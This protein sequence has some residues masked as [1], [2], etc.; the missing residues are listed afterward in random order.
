MVFFVDWFSFS[1]QSHNTAPVSLPEGVREE[2]CQGTNIYSYR[3]I[4]YYCGWKLFTVLGK[5]H[6]KI[7]RQDLLLVEVGN[8]WLYGYLDI[9]GM[10]SV[11]Y[12]MAV[13]NNLSRVDLCCDFNVGEGELDIIKGLADG[14]YYVGGKR[15][16]V[17][18]YDVESNERIPRCLNFGS[19]QSEVKWK[20]YNKVKEI[21]AGTP[22]CTKP[23]IV[24]QWLAMGMGCSHVWRLE[25]SLHADNFK[26]DNGLGFDFTDLYNLHAIRRMFLQLYT[27]RF[28]VKERGHSRRENDAVKL[29]LPLSEPARQRKQAPKS[30]LNT[31]QVRATLSHLIKDYI[32]GQREVSDVVQNAIGKAILSCCEEYGLYSY[33]LEKYNVDVRHGVESL[34]CVDPR[35][36]LRG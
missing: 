34:Y 36:V 10:V 14:R 15:S 13:V 32:N 25:A 20:L 16:G 19:I 35:K 6:S 31:M 3:R 1:L 21:G 12:P 29:L 11:M 28:V 2:V 8:R 27:F 9:M 22:D 26:D 30:S 18:F 7:L 23:Y 4:Y 5:P 24:D 33:V 17:V